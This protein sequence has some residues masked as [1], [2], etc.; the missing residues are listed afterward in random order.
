[1]SDLREE[2]Q[3]RRLRRLV[4]I[5]VVAGLVVLIGF[6][7]WLFEVLV[8]PA[9]PR[10]VTMSTG[11]V[12]GAYHTFALRYRAHLARYGVDLILKQSNGSMENSRGSGS[13]GTVCRWPWCRAGLP[14]RRKRR[15]S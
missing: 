1:M 6:F 8:Q 7:A 10:S 12:D 3:S 5:A 2:A 4:A 11:P 13:R 14:R 9:P 15:E